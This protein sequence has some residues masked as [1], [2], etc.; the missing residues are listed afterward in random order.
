[1]FPSPGGDVWVGAFV[2]AL[3]F[4][5]EQFPLGYYLGCGSMV[6]IYGATGFLYRLDD[7][8]LLLRANPILRRRVH[9]PSQRKA[10]P[11]VNE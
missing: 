10:K 6:L 5:L 3:L 2:A 4:N 8:D 1:M 7:V 11:K 9:P